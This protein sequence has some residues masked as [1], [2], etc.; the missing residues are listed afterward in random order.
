VVTH[1]LDLARRFPRV[2][3][4]LDGNLQPAGETP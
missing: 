2:V 1:S 4:M 3:E